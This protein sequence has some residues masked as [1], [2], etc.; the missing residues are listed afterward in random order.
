MLEKLFSGEV[1]TLREKQIIQTISLNSQKMMYLLDNIIL[2]SLESNVIVK[3]NVFLE[4]LAKS[5]DLS[6]TNMAKK[7]GM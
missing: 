2:P 6:L 3:F 7:F 4:V 1:I 5:D